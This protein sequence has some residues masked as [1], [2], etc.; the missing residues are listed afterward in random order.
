LNNVLKQI[1][2]IN[3]PIFWSVIGFALLIV[4]V[5]IIGKIRDRRLI[6]SVTSLNRG[7]KS[8]REF[9]LSLLKHDI[10][11][12]TIFHDLCVR[13][14]NGKFSQIDVVVV[15]TQGIL[16]FE[17]KDFSGWIFGS[18]NN[19]HWTKVLA[20]GKKKYRFYNPIKQNTNHIKA[21]KS[22]L[23]QF[24]K[25]PF[26][27]IITFYGDCELKDIN[28]VPE[29]T[30]LTKPQRVFEVIRLIKNN[31]VPAPYTDK[32]G[33]ITTL[34]Q[35]VNYGA[36]LKNQEKHVDNINDMLGKHRIFD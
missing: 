28:Y 36:I 5:K 21:L 16:V 27:S 20:Y 33:V 3:N 31:N 8:E 13:K 12:Q 9:I 34:K 2:N 32:R 11:S 19:S 6:K 18:G 35:A 17:V 15:T 25:I 10:P 22:Q 30:Y 23:K 1:A 26:F 14:N 7:T 4:I 24:D 29:G